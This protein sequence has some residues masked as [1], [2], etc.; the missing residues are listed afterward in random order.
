M[1]KAGKKYVFLTDKYDTMKLTV[2]RLSNYTNV[3]VA[4]GLPVINSFGA[5][6]CCD[7]V[8]W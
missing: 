8:T 4:A 6:L 5:C 7:V 1:N 2:H 3:T